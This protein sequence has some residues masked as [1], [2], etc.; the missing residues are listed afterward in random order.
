MKKVL[1]LA[2]DFPP[3]VSVGG[4]RPAGWAKYLKKEN[5]FPTVVTRQWDDLDGTYLDYIRPSKLQQLEHIVEVT[6]E[7]YRV[8]FRPSLGNKLLLKHGPERFKKR[9]AILNALHEIGQFFFPIGTKRGL[10]KE[11]RILLKQESFDVVI[12]TGDP[13]ILFHYLKKLKKEFNIPCIADYRDPWS[14]DVYLQQHPTLSK[15]NKFIECKTLKNIQHISS[16]S[17]FLI[18]NLNDLH[19][20]KNY[21]VIPNGFDLENAI[22]ASSVEQNKEVLSLA[23]VGTICSWYPI[24][25][26]LSTLLELKQDVGFNFRLNL[27]GID[28]VEYIE[29]LLETTY[30]NIKE[31]VKITAKVPNKELMEQLAQNNLLILFNSFSFLGTKIFDYVAVNRKI[32][33]L[34]TEDETTNRL[35]EEHFK[36]EERNAISNSLQA[37]MILECNAGVS[38]QNPEHLKK[39]LLEFEAEFHSTRKIKNSSTGFEQF[40]RQA[41]TKKLATIIHSI[42]S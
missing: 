29:S 9:R 36:I 37:D 20:E 7:E 11:A 31:N 25:L 42:S 41:Q 30:I 24:E 39:L 14:Q 22:I 21:H 33:L 18:A 27:L 23:F 19:G 35:K 2:Y 34:F 6:H 5:I 38:V 13:F 15:L 26:F 10:Y 17:E 28:R 16:V 32:L 12:A 4:L 8:P 40:S 3:Y 1:I